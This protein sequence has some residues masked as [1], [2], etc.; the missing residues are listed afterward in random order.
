MSDETTTME[1]AAELLA[2]LARGLG[3]DGWDLVCTRTDSEGVDFAGG[4]ADQL[5]LQND[6][7]LG[8]RIFRDGRPGYASTGRLTR[9]AIERMVRDAWDH[10]FLA[11]PMPV[12]LPKPEAPSAPEPI[13]ADP[14]VESLGL[15]EL[16]KFSA[17]LDRRVRELS[18]EIEE[19][20][21]LGAEKTLF[22]SLFLN[23]NG[24]SFSRRVTTVAAG[25]G[26][27]LS[28]NGQTK[29]GV[30]TLVRRGPEAL[31]A[32]LLAVES[33]E[34]GR[35]LLGAKPVESGEW[36]ILFENR[37][38]G[39][40]MGMY[41][42]SLHALAAQKGQS[43]LAGKTGERIASE[44]L[45]LRDDPHRMDLSGSRLFDS[46]GVP[47]RP[48]VPIEKGI[49][50]EWL[51]CLESAAREGARPTGN[52]SRGCSGA[53]GTS[54]RNLIVDRGSETR[55]QLMAR[56]PRMLFVTKLEGATGCSAISGELS[57]GVQG[58]LV[59][60][61]EIVRPVDHVTVSGDW[62]RMLREIEGVGDSYADP[63]ASTQVPDL[64]FER[65]KV[66]G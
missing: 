36:P 4:K 51:H 61:G 20:P 59:E 56:H 8:I 2:S 23:S 29:M 37:I 24:V 7:G 55:A 54:F 19:I 9:P 41:G 21:E 57:I 39:A 42:S 35:S 50:K 12:E 46:E 58:F 60:G 34:R 53:A 33:V 63:Y 13:L 31:D 48:I 40:L 66:S 44:L 47:T 25:L 16:E 65:A 52:G 17:A 49:L 14:A 5:R 45:T 11:D 28:R 18:D 15:P 43:R 10:T 22:R 64:L 62:F 26:V 32:E 27:V 3:A 30:R 6:R 38:A 1:S